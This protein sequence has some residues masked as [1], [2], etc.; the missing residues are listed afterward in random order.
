MCLE[1]ND[2]RSG[3]VSVDFKRV[4]R[5]RG[6]GSCGRSGRRR[7]RGLARPIGVVG[8]A[9]VR[10]WVRQIELVVKRGGFRRW[11][12]RRDCG[13]VLRYAQG[14]KVRLGRAVV[15]LSWG[16]WETGNELWRGPLRPSRARVEKH[17]AVGASRGRIVA[18]GT[19]ER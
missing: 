5:L 16:G 10:C 6:G 19:G 14:Y 13:G 17:F 9:E 2:L 4:F 12:M 7:G 1:N 8:E 18:Q 15:G 3:T 11:L